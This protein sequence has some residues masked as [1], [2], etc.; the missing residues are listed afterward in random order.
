MV[1]SVSSYEIYKNSI[2]ATCII[3]T[4]TVLPFFFG[5]IQIYS[6]FTL[7][8]CVD[9]L[10]SGG[11]LQVVC[12]GDF[13]ITW[14][15]SVHSIGLRSQVYDSFL[16]E[17]LASHGDTVDDEHNFSS[18]DGRSFREDHLDVRGHVTGMRPRSQG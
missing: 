10:H 12:M 6:G 18:S 1:R 2:F 3:V 4:F 7:F 8:G 5:K 17:F 13:P 15:T 11:I 16:E 14:S 9:D